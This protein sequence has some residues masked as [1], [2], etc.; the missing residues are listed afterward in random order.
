MDYMMD[1]MMHRMVEWLGLSD[2]RGI[3]IAADVK[4]TRTCSHSHNRSGGGGACGGSG[5]GRKPQRGPQSEQSV[6]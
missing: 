2:L 6:P 3:N 4:L 1:N 5:G